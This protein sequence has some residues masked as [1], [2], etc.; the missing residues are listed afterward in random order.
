MNLVWWRETG[1]WN[2]P[3]R[4]ALIDS[5]ETSITY[6]ELN[7]LANKAGNALRDRF[8]IQENDVVATLA[9]ETRWHVAVM[10]GLWKIGAVFCPLNRTQAHGK[11][12]YDLEITRPKLLLVS[13]RFSEVGKRL[14]AAEA[15]EHLAVLDEDCG[16]LQNFIESIESASS[17]L[18]M[19][20]RASD[21]LATIN[22]TTGTTGP[23]KGAMLTHGALLTSYLSGGHWA[24][25]RGTD[26][27]LCPLY[28]FHT[29]GLGVLLTALVAH[30]TVIMMGEP[31]QNDR[32]IDF[33]EKYK[34]DWLFLMVP[35]MTRDLAR[36]PR[37]ADLDCSNLKVHLAGE[38]VSPEVQAM[39]EERGARTL[40]LYGMTET[41]PLCVTSNSF[42]Y[43]DDEVVGKGLAGKENREFGIV[44]LI[45]PL[46][47]KEITKPGV[48]G[49]I[50]F[51]GDV[52]TPGYY[53]DPEKTKMSID[54][55]GWFHTFDLGIRDENGY[56]FVGGRTDD[57]ILS[58]GEKLSLIEVETAILQAPF[59]K[60]AAC[61]GIPHERFGQSPVAF[62]TPSEDMSEEE[63]KETLQE[64]L[65]RHL[66]RWKRPRLYVKMDE[67]PRSMAKRVKIWP[68]LRKIVDG[69]T[70][71]GN[72]A[73]T[74]GAYRLAKE[75]EK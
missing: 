3:D 44:K 74:L 20:P 19:T 13:P 51:K 7:A 52:L 21:D 57:I 53:G 58:G 22:F 59:V 6:A 68:E 47:G 15:V 48:Q 4:K 10:F 42:Q 16:D 70:L 12:L 36:N 29:G 64:F 34:P 11:F 31:W 18:R 25:M 14:Y 1:E 39:W 17:E 38:P 46:T 35:V 65:L 72:G 73:T 56:Y 63:L 2:N 9:G 49:E 54:E 5:S 43:G 24:G 32:M 61:V 62:V 28:M 33:L 67:I 23:S 69:V 8:G 75:S 37:F 55:D 71:S 40:I 26:T 27:V 41:M 45:D 30:A 66:E 60:D 50:C